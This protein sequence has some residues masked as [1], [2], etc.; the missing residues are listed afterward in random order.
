MTA[1]LSDQQRD[2]TTY[3]VRTALDTVRIEAR[4]R[5]AVSDAIEC[6]PGFAA[7]WSG[8]LAVQRRGP[9]GPEIRRFREPGILM[10]LEATEAALARV[11]DGEYTLKVTERQQL[12]DIAVWLE[13]RQ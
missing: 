3:V 4:L 2:L 7:W 6:A 5:D 13:C 1:T 11:Q 10:S 9:R 8:R 12:D